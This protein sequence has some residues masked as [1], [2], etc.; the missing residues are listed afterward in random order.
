[1]KTLIIVRG[2]SGAGKSTLANTICNDVYSADDYFMENGEYKFNPKKLKDA[3][4][5]CKSKV[6]SAM[7]WNIDLVA[8]ANTFTR[9]WEMQAYFD[10]AKQYGYVV[11]TIIVE[12]R[13]GGKN[14]HGVPEHA[15]QSMR[16]R[17]EVSL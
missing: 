16:D 13:H 2:V 17:F 11:H 3:H 6:E 9:E 15:L 14:C 8:V 1:M 5:W 12:N 10:L 4:A 7:E